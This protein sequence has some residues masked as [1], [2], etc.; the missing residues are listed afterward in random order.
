MPMLYVTGFI[1]LFM[2][3]WID[4]FLILRYYKSAAYFTKHLSKAVVKILP[5][6]L[7][8]HMIFGLFM[9]SWPD[10]LN[11]NLVNHWFGTSMLQHLTKERL[12]QYHVLIFEIASMFLLAVFLFRPQIKQLVH[13]YKGRLSMHQLL[14]N[15]TQVFSDDIYQELHFGQLHTEWKRLKLEEKRYNLLTNQDSRSLSGT[16]HPFTV[17]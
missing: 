14:P 8:L 7:F 16:R 3:Y 1:S 17:A 15:E 4:K 13:L 2:A 12:S 6:A 11:S 5:L 9:F 10:G